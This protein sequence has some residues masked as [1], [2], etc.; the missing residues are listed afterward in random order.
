M[1]HDRSRFAVQ[2]IHGVLAGG[3]VLHMGQVEVMQFL[4][5]TRNLSWQ[6]NK[7]YNKL[8]LQHP[9]LIRCPCI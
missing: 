8:H 5:P 1:S 9:Y 6:H 4:T 7:K 3:A 2:Y